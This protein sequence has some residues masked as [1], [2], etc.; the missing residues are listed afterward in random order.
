[1]QR[2]AWLQLGEV[3]RALRSASSAEQGGAEAQRQARLQLARLKLH[4]DEQLAAL[5]G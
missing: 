5:G 2:L 3:R 4:L 1:V